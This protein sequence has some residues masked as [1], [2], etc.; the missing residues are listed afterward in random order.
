MSMS[1]QEGLHA[2]VNGLIVDVLVK[3]SVEVERMPLRILLQIHFDLWLIDNELI[4]GHVDLNDIELSPIRFLHKAHLVIRPSVRP[5]ILSLLGIALP[6]AFATRVAL[7]AR[8]RYEQQPTCA[9][10][11]LLRT[12]TEILGGALLPAT[13]VGGVRYRVMSTPVSRSGVSLN[14]MFEAPACLLHAATT[15]H[16]ARTHPDGEEVDHCGDAAV[17][18]LGESLTADR[19]S[20]LP[21]SSSRSSRLLLSKSSLSSIVGATLP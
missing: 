4:G 6:N 15:L 18:Q 12:M 20:P 17:C 9:F 3:H 19:R 1:R 14:G 11:G 2:P 16:D 7:L 8:R 10:S 5:T 21:S 13:E